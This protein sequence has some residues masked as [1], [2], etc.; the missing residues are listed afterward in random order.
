[1]KLW[2]KPDP[3]TVQETTS[4]VEAFELMNTNRF[5][6]IP[7]VDEQHQLV[8]IV[9]KQ[10]ISNALPSVI[11]G[12]DQG[13]SKALFEAGTVADVMT[14]S[15]ISVDSDTSLENLAQTMRKHKFGGAPVVEDGKLVGIITES[16]VFSAFMEAL[17]ADRPGLRLEVFVGKSSRDLY[18]LIDLF[19]RHNM[20]L[21]T[22]TVHH[23]FSDRQHLVTIKVAGDDYEDLLDTMRD[24]SIQIHRISEEEVM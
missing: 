24:A 18:R 1:M 7:V 15:P 3:V 19:K 10:D 20:E 12:S 11:D 22:V 14:R 9:S 5:R 13:V 23:D 6:R 21:Q 17:G 16:D 8:G 2:M 4:L